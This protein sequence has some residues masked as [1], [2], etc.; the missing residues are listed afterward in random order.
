MPRIRVWSEL[1]LC[2]GKQA[3]QTLHL[4]HWMSAQSYPVKHSCRLMFF[5]GLALIWSC[6]GGEDRGR[7]QVDAAADATADSAPVDCEPVDRSLPSFG[8]GTVKTDSHCEV[9]PPGA[10]WATCCVKGRIEKCYCIFG[11]GCEFSAGITFCEQSGT[12]FESPPPVVGIC[13]ADG[14]V[15]A[16]SDLVLRD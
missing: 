15:D 16:P 13:S 7:S 11:S 12:C 9:L 10:S 1:Y 5:A 8:H 14:G 3:A 2:T 4:K 6:G